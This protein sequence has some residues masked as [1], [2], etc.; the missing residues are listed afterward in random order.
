MSDVS[1]EALALPMKHRLI[2]RARLEI[3]MADEP[4]VLCLAARRLRDAGRG[5]KEGDTERGEETKGAHASLLQWAVDR[6]AI[7]TALPQAWQ[8]PA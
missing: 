6:R 2:R 8:V 5:E 7:V 1:D 3:V 4:H